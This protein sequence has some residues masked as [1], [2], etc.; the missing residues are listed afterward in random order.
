[1]KIKYA[2]AKF[3]LL[4]LSLLLMIHCK[5]E[6]INE[7]PPSSPIVNA[8]IDTIIPTGEERYLKEDSDYIF[9]QDKLPTFEL[10]IPEAHLARMDADPAAEKYESASLTFEGETI[11]PVGVRYKGSIG[12]YTG[13][14]S[15]GSWFDPSGFKTC[16]KLSMKIKINWEGREDKFYGLKKIQLHSMNQDQSQMR[17]RLGYWLFAQMGVPAPRA[18]HARLMI[19]GE[20]AG[21]FALVEQVDGRFARHHF[22]DG[23]GNVYK[24]IWPLTEEG[25]PQFDNRYRDALE[26]NTNEVSNFNIIKGLAQEVSESNN[27]EL[28][29]LVI[30]KWTD[31]EKLIAYCMVD[32]TIKHDDG[33][34][35]WYCVNGCSPHNFY[36]VEEPTNQ[37]IHLIPWDLDNAFENLTT[38]NPVTNILDDWGQTRNDCNPFIVGFFDL[39][40]RSA[41]CDRFTYGMTLFEEEY[42]ELQQ[43]FFNGAFSEE[44]IEAQL[45]LW[46]DQISQATSEADSKFNDAVSPT[47]WLN[48]IE[49]LKTQCSIARS[50]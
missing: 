32:R 7:V 49:Q 41:A 35:H 46:A 8:P 29:K 31:I 2:F 5:K 34:F 22:D 6:P 3:G 44:S 38:P 14:L 10:T 11:S 40:Q 17:D 1:M 26:S 9:N 16:S 25:S 30:K 27:D 36:F 21:L 43:A 28:L 42:F 39:R 20:Y 33:P 18:I 47:N 23:D 4:L 37:K 45:Q 24:E 19:N 15:G 48:A 13:C 12:A 50:Q